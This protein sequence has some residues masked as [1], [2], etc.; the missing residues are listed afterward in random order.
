MMKNRIRA[1]RKTL[2]LSQSEFAGRLGIKSTALSMVELGKNALTEQNIKLVCMVFNVN[3]S[4]LRTGEGEMFDASPYEKEFFGI[5]RGLMPETQQ[6]LLRL[7]RDMLE[8]QKNLL[9]G[10]GRNV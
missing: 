5:Y 7:A 8:S 2:K 4:W 6:A 10:K 3:D 1:I 9:N